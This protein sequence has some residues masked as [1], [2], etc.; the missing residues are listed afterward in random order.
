MIHERLIE[1]L[2]DAGFECTEK[3]ERAE[4]YIWKSGHDFI[5]V[6]ICRRKNGIHVES[7]SSGHTLM[8]AWLEDI[9]QDGNRICMV[10]GMGKREICGYRCMDRGRTMKHCDR[11]L[12]YRREKR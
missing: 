8:R 12:S 10:N 4:R 5:I 7:F 11:C 3:T 9:M 1:L 6:T 2:I